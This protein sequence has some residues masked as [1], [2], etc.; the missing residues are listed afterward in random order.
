MYFI[1]WL[2]F[3]NL[4]SIQQSNEEAYS[5]RTRTFKMELFAQIVK[6]FQLLTLFVKKSILDVWLDSEYPSENN[7]RDR[8][9]QEHD[10][11][12]CSEK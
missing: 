4:T 3:S 2:F 10:I 6:S 1:S 12:I 7:K 8:L 9:F 5:V 11:D